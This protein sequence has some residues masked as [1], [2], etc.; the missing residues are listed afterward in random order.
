MRLRRNQKSSAAKL[1]KP[2][3]YPVGTYVQ[4][5]KGYFYI[6]SATGRMYISSDRIL[7]SWAPP[8]VAQS[9]E[10]QLANYRITSRMKMRNGSL[11]HSVADGRIY[12]IEGGKR[13]HIVGPN[14]LEAIGAVYNDA[15]TVSQ[16]ELLLHEEGEPLK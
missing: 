4:T 6:S 15:V 2:T 14:V 12:L 10:A 3:E 7:N 16:E 8:R 1:S 13:R 9:S 11:I 5:E